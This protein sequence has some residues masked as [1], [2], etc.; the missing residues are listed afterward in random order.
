[1]E[2][3][4]AAVA[5]DLGVDA[6]RWNALAA[7]SDTNTVYQ[8]YEWN[9]SWWMTIGRRF[10]PLFLAAT[11]EAGA[12]GIAP[13]MLQHL[14]EGR[15]VRFVGDGRADY[16]DVLAAG[17]KDAVIAAMVRRLLRPGWD[18][19]ELNNIPEASRTPRIVQVVCAE[20]GYRTLTTK[21]FV[22][23]T[24]LIA[25]RE[26]EARAVFNKPSL[27]RRENVL[28]RGG[29]LT[30]RHLRA[31]DEIVPHLDAFFDQHVGRWKAGKRGRS[32]FEDER[33]REFYRELTARLS[34]RGWL[35]FSVVEFDGRPIAFHFGFDYDGA[36][37]WY[38]P[39]FDISLASRSPGLVLVRNLIGYALDNERREFDFT[40]GE[41]AFKARFTNAR[42]RTVSIRVYRTQA[43]YAVDAARARMA[44]LV[45]R[46]SGDRPAPRT[47]R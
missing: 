37:M 39:S 40:V 30:C 1:M 33:N 6:D 20:A 38:K 36:V 35:L 12:V 45:R 22:C 29:T 7:C 44:R 24:L 19:V 21:Q 11:E 26:E 17:D 47:S 13:L 31:G 42:R 15:V 3:R 4:V 9:S 46:L 8:T 43:R 14:P 16:C 23:P 18:V 34:H 27:R 5:A 10:E 41:E 28:R 25:G 2:V 32:L